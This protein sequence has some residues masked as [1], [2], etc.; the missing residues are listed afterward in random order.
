M[1]PLLAF[2]LLLS[3]SMP[4][5]AEEAAKKPV[6]AEAAK[7]IVLRTAHTMSL[8]DQSITDKRL[9]SDIAEKTKELEATMPVF[10]WE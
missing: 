10:L 6:A 1:R 4:V 5:I 8:E 7:A 2:S 9:K 3:L